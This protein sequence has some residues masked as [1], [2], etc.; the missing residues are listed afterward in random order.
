MAH[1]WPGASCP[2]FG[3]ALPHRRIARLPAT[4]PDLFD[5]HPVATGAR[6]YDDTPRRTTHD[7]IAP[8][9]SHFPRH[10][11]PSQQTRKTQPWPHPPA[12]RGLAPAGNRA[13][14]STVEAENDLASRAP[15]HEPPS[16]QPRPPSRAPVAARGHAIQSSLSSSEHVVRPGPTPPS[17]PTPPSDSLS[18]SDSVFRNR[19]LVMTLLACHRVPRCFLRAPLPC[20]TPASRVSAPR[21]RLVIRFQLSPCRVGCL[22]WP[23]RS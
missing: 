21:S 6:G 1:E 12:H 13:R 3:A 20:L 2:F 19:N 5:T 4:T 23:C 8:E 16:N 15:A 17:S 10:L 9:A 7:P 18:D 22:I 11:L 14:A